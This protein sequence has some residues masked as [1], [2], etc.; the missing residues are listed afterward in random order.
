MVWLWLPENYNSEIKGVSEL[1]DELA[2]KIGRR[3]ATIP[4]FIE[5]NKQIVAG[6]IDIVQAEVHP[7]HITVAIVLEYGAG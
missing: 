5:D 2:I 6:S 7:H 4:K 1:H 3:L